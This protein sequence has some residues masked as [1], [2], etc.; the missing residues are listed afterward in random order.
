MT[1]KVSPDFEAPADVGG[2]NQYDIVV[3]AI[4]NGAVHDVTKAVAI[5]VT[6]VNDP[7]VIDLDGGGDAASV[8]VNENATAVTTVTATEPEAQT[9]TFSIVTGAGSPDAAEFDIDG[10]GNL[11]F[12]A[13]P[14]FEAP[15][16]AASSN[17]YKVQVQV[18]DNGSPNAHD[19]QTI[20]IDVQD[21]NDTAPTFTSS[22]T[23]DV[24]EGATA[25][26]TLT[27]TDADTV[28]RIRQP[29]A[30]PAARIAACSRSQAA[31]SWPS[32]RR[33]TTRPRPT[34]MPCRSLRMTAATPRFKTLRS[35]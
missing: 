22:A 17:S 35:G 2:N 7:P 25:V 28:G 6:D 14:D 1:F 26:V 34:A 30:S 16:S 31:I 24:A 33:T 19:I 4:D 5:T 13:A 21:L 9:L 8:S 10:L 3:H 32:R 15:G 20:T 18:T 23:P 12:K 27:A 11:S 29:S